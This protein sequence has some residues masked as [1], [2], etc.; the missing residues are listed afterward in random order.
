MPR[1]SVVMSTYN[2]PE[3]Y[4]REA[5]ESILI[6][7]FKDFELIIVDDGSEQ[8]DAEIASE[9]KDDRIIVLKNEKNSGLAYSLNR[10]LNQAKGEYIVRMDSDDI[11]FP[12]RLQKQIDYMDSHYDIDILSSRAECFGSR[13]GMPI[14]DYGEDEYVKATLFFAD[15]ILHPTVVMR[16][17]SLKKYGL[18]Y[19]DRLRRAQDYDLWARAS[20]NCRFYIMPDKLLHYRCH[21]GQAT[22]IAREKQLAVCR[23]VCSYYLSRLGLESNDNSVVYHRALNGSADQPVSLYELWQWT[24]M[25]L[26]ANNER[27]L[28]DRDI[29][30]ELVGYRL[31]Y[32]AVKLGKRKKLIHSGKAFFH[33]FSPH[34]IKMVSKH[35]KRNKE[36]VLDHQEKSL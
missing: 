3:K 7:T 9:F 17:D 6:Q 1:A 23:M 32:A 36:F 35:R 2:T 24:E 10:G 13:T 11:A 4:L 16:K 28:F 25:L 19:D 34:N 21:E 33:V 12:D 20:E 26:K 15:L 30:S 31:V 5:I 18:L 27:H 29:F 22:I 14:I 8:N